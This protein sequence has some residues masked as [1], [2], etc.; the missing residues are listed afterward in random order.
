MINSKMNPKFWVESFVTCRSNLTEETLPPTEK[1]KLSHFIWLCLTMM[2]LGIIFIIFNLLAGNTEIACTIGVFSSSIAI[3]LIMVKKCYNLHFIY[4]F[5]SFL[6]FMLLVI[7]TYLEPNSEGRVLWIYTYPLFTIFVFG[8]KLGIMWSIL[9]IFAVGSCL[10]V[11]HTD[12][13]HY[14]EAFRLRFYLTY[15]VIVWITAWLEYGRSRHTDSLQDEITRRIQLEQQLT[16]L[17]E[18]D[19]LTNL[20]NRSSMWKLANREIERTKQHDTEL[21]LAVMDIDNFKAVND[22][23]GHPT[24]DE[25]IKY[26]SRLLSQSLRKSDIACRLGGEE[27]A[28]LIPETSTKEA[29]KI[30]DRFRKEMSQHIFNAEGT[31]FQVTISI[32]IYSI[33]KHN[34]SFKQAYAKADKALY[35]AKQK[36]KNTVCIAE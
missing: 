17:A 1:M 16:I 19:G 15:L 2:P 13:P 6:F 21:S 27:F 26:V 18:K 8:Y 7:V 29:H 3:N 31:N 10:E 30:M 35:Q 22:T 11:L 5:C 28:A 20:Y 4:H 32:G 33:S 14:L 9:L 12:I 34:A 24:G 36:G 23:Y 25:V